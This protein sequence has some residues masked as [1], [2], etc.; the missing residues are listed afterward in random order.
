MAEDE[1]EVDAQSENSDIKDEQESASE[2]VVDAGIAESNGS[3][4]I[5]EIER[6]TQVE[7]VIVDDKLK[8]VRVA[9]LF[10]AGDVEGLL[11]TLE[12]NFNV[13]YER[14]SEE[15]IILSSK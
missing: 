6:Y 1:K 7:F 12:E 3:E 4:A 11:T 15:K 8:Q 5:A 10:K 13:V 14:V 2:P 9:G